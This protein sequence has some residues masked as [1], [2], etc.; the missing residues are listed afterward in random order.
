MQELR[1]ELRGL[2]RER[3]R[4]V[5]SAIRKGRAVA[6]PRD[7]A[8]AV[9][10][11]EHLQAVSWPRWIMPRTRP[12]G[13]RAWAWCL[14]GLWVLGAFVLG[15]IVIWGSLPSLWRW[16]IVGFFASSLPSGLITMRQALVGYWNAPETAARNRALLKGYG[17]E[18]THNLRSDL[19]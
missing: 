11:A 5:V 14:H 19:Q 18:K 15:W 6:N 10:W 16:L 9:A 4:D 7:A 12:E 3:R 1:R 2:P 8:L 13:W 17:S